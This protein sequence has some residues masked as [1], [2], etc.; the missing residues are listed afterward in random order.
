MC[1]IR[2]W[3]LTYEKKS[4]GDVFM[5]ND[6][7]CKTIGIRTIQIKMHD[8]VIRTLTEVR[9]VPD[10]KKNLI[11]VGVLDTK[12][13]K[14]NVEGEAMEISKGSIVV[15]RGI[16]K[17]NLYMLQGSTNSIS[18]SISVTDKHTPDLTHL[19]YMLLGHMSE[20]GMM[21]L[22]KQQLLGDHII[23][24]LK[25]CEH[26]VFGKYH[27]IKFPKAQHT[28][29]STLD[30]VHSD[31]WGPSRVPSLGGGRYFLSI[32]DDYSRMTWIFIMKH[33]NQAF[34]Y[35]KE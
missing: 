25:F 23:K 10:L 34:K 30:Y 7:A 3:F 22:S 24:E 5:G 13:F 6:M 9:H 29:K 27:R 18:E 28:T 15:I 4:G 35:F 11:S 2:S 32:I 26:C 19:W 1:P 16:N 12:G 8:G 20:R 21:V 33:K 14:C 17:G 31:Y